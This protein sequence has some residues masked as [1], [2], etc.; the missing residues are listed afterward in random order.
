MLQR[1]GF[2]AGCRSR[3]HAMGGFVALR[4]GNGACPLHC[5]TGVELQR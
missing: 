4:V 5:A 1:N 2:A 3:R